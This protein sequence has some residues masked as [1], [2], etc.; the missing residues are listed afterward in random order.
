MGFMVA[1]ADRFDSCLPLNWLHEATTD[2]IAKF[3]WANFRLS[4]GSNL[5]GADLSE[6]KTRWEFWPACCGQ[7]QALRADGSCSST[8]F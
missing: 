8:S 6:Q 4:C 3:L 5:A 1:N 7:G 2:Q